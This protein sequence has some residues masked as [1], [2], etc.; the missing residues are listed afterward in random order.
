MRI[1]ILLDIDKLPAST[2]DVSTGPFIV[3][4]GLGEFDSQRERYGLLETATAR[5]RRSRA[6]G[7]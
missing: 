1:T 4:S 6:G 3:A 2:E 7:V 5:L